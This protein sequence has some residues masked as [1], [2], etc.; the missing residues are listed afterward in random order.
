MKAIWDYF[1]TL[2]KELWYFAGVFFSD[3]NLIYALGTFII[4][5][6]FTRCATATRTATVRH[7][8]L[9]LSVIRLDSEAAWT[10]GPSD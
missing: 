6:V 1:R 8:G 5:N 9:H 4:V 2:K 3:R 7:T 10:V